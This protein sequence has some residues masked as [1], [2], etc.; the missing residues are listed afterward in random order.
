MTT[1]V[2]ILATV[3]FAF[4]VAVILYWLMRWRQRQLGKECAVIFAVFGSGLISVAAIR[5]TRRLHAP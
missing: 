1:L 2:Y 3:L 5:R 4:A